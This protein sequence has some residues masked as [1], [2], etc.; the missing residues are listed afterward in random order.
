MVLGYRL[1][2]GRMRDCG[3]FGLIC[4]GMTLIHGGDK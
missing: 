1:Q 2:E 3:W 4:A